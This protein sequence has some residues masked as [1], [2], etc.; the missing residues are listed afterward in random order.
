[1]PCNQI[2]GNI[3][4]GM[5]RESASSAARIL[6]S[7]RSL[8][9]THPHRNPNWNSPVPLGISNSVFHFDSLYCVSL[10]IAYIHRKKEKKIKSKQ[11]EKKNV[12]SVNMLEV[13]Y[14]KMSR[15]DTRTWHVEVKRKKK[16]DRGG[17]AE[18]P[19][20]V[21][22]CPAHPLGT[23]PSPTSHTEKRPYTL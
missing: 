21:D 7:A 8:S 11:R 4:G 13:G 15:R 2:K 12:S 1:M 20:L 19:R 14:M 10:K 17:E 23:S 3:V 6:K 18:G 22:K 5:R 16:K 9:Q